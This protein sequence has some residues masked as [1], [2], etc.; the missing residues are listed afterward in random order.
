[1]AQLPAT[2]TAVAVRALAADEHGRGMVVVS[3]DWPA[4]SSST[5]PNEPVMPARHN[6][7][8]IGQASERRENSGRAFRCGLP[9]DR[10][11]PA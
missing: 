8:R 2:T 1:M 10:L 9:D 11:P 7:I 5:P 3:E 6:H 4:H